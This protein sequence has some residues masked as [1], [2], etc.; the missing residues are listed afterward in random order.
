G[1]VETQVGY[2]GGATENP[3]Y[4]QVCSGATGHAETVEITFDQTIVSYENLLETFWQIHDPAQ[5]NRQGPDVGTQYR[6]AIFTL[7]NTQNSAA[8]KS[9][10]QWQNTHP[11]RPVATIIEPLNKFYKAEQYHQNYICNKEAAK[12]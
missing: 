3:T 4:Q 1:V 6:S 2:C 10:E 9:K 5:I 8:E 7:H 11:G 12:T